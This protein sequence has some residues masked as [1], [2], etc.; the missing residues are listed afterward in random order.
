MYFMH[1]HK[2][3]D[4]TASFYGRAQQKLATLTDWMFSMLMS[5]S[6]EIPEPIEK[7][8]QV[9]TQELAGVEFPGAGTAVLERA[10]EAARA[11]AD[12]LAVAEA[13]ADAARD[14]LAEAEAELMRKAQR[15]LAYARIYA[16]EAPALG[17]RLDEI[18]LRPEVAAPAPEQRR[19][20]RPRKVATGT[21]LFALPEP[22]PLADG[23]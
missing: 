17:T 13:A 20:G 23:T 10:I 11:A 8:I 2:I 21:P 1:L 5:T 6:F 14:A 16:E 4:A 12:R 3:I 15:A 19:R 7:L 9:F 18:V 22:E